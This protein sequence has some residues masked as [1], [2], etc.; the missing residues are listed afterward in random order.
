M[1][2]RVV[3]REKAHCGSSRRTIAQK[4]TNGC[5]SDCSRVTPL[6]F[7]RLVPGMAGTKKQ[8]SKLQ[9]Q[10]DPGRGGLRQ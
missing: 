8:F 4:K 10:K 5:L 3:Y 1:E 7:L 2:N 6:N 9:T